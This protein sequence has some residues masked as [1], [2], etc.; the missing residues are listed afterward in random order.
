MPPR[1]WFSYL[2]AGRYL[3][4][5]R[6][7]FI[8]SLESREEVDSRSEDVFHRI[9]LGTLTLRGSQ[10]FSL[11]EAAGAQEALKSRATTG[12]LLLVS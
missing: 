8:H 2:E 1:A 4:L 9:E 10:S 12:N 7:S 11:A 5:A 3:F 6:P